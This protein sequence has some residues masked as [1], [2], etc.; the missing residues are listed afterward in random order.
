M[1]A[2]TIDGKATAAAERERIATEVTALG[3]HGIVP[4]LAAVLVGDDPASEVYVRQKERMCER[5]GM[6]SLGE[7]LDAEVSQSEL[8]EVVDRLNADPAVSGIIVQMPLPDH[9]DEVEAQERTDPTKDVDGLHP[10]NAGRLMRGDPRFVPATPLGCAVLLAT[11]EIAVSGA[12][13][14][15]LGRSQ[16]V[17][18]PLATLL[19]AKPSPGGPVGNATVTV[20]HTRTRDL[21]AHT[22]AADVIVVAAGVAGALTADMVSPGA[23]V[24]DVGIHR[25]EDGSL[26]G[27]V[28]DPTVEEV[29]GAL[30]PV[31]GG[32]GPMTVTMLLENT[33]R[34]AR[35]Q[36]GLP[37]V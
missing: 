29:A 28:T 37:A 3:E 10:E 33:V 7:R 30:T 11:Y 16:L 5:V 14:V 17:G 15:V 24:I 27:D 32:V 21:A 22:R 25:A 2:T 6:R 4:G 26:H 1:G 31:P 12:N 9:L 8:L 34:A 18:R 36:A 19:S 20:C 13:I 23:T 35:I